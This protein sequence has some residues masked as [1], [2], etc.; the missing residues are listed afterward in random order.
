MFSIILGNLYN[1]VI[2]SIVELNS[3]LLF[4]LF[5]HLF[6]RYL[7]PTRCQSF[8]EEIGDTRARK[9]NSNIFSLILEFFKLDSIKNHLSVRIG[10]TLGCI[11]KG[12]G[13]IS[14]RDCDVQSTFYLEV[15][16]WTL[17]WRLEDWRFLFHNVPPSGL[18]FYELICMRANNPVRLFSP[19]P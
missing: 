17:P 4:Q 11:I 9:T 5:I 16:E 13:R 3:Y 19:H 18:Q 7:V 1:Y 15:F 8:S 6:R 12:S 14:Y 10:K 2:F